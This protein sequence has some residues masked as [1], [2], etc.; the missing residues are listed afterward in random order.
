MSPTIGFN[1]PRFS[2]IV[3]DFNEAVQPQSLLEQIQC[4]LVESG[5][6]GEIIVVNNDSTDGIQGIIREF[7]AK[8]QWL[9]VTTVVERNRDVYA[10]IRAGIAN[11]KGNIMFLCEPRLPT[12]INDLRVLLTRL[13]QRRDRASGTV[14]VEIGFFKQIQRMLMGC[15]WN[16]LAFMHG[17]T[18]RSI[19]H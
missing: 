8:H 17:R 11:A 19:V 2:I 4:C 10:E 9:R 12:R 16:M 1:S 3:P 5:F 13:S 18:R 7:A 15:L 14:I 6:A